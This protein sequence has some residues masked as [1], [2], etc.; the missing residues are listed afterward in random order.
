MKKITIFILAF[1]SV[2]SSHNTMAAPTL[3]SDGMPLVYL[4]GDFNRTNWQPNERYRFSRSGD[5][6]TLVIDEKNA[7]GECSFKI[8]DDEWGIVDLGAFDA[9]IS[10]SGYVEGVRGAS[11]MRTPGLKDAI[12]SFTYTP[13]GNTTIKFV[14]D[15]IEPEPGLEPEPIPGDYPEIYLVGELTSDRWAFT[16]KRFKF[17]NNGNIYTLKI[18]G[19]NPVPAGAQFKIATSDWSTFDIG[20]AEQGITIDNTQTLALRRNGANLKTENGIFD[21]SISFTLPEGDYDYVGVTFTITG[22]DPVMPGPVTGLSGTLPV[23]Y[24][25]V[26]IDEAH[27]AYNNEII[28]KDLSHKNY[29]DYAEYWLDVNGCQWLIDEGAE[30]VGSAEKPL[31]LQIKARGNWTRI[32]FS[33]KPFKLK[34]DK[35]QSLLGLSKSKHFAILAHAD[36][37]KGYLR[38]FTGF[39]LGKRIGLPWTP[40]QQPVEV[41]INGD[42]RGLYFLTESI[43]VDEDRVNIEE[44]GDNV[45]DKELVSGGYIVE[46]DNYDEDDNAQI[47][48]DERVHPDAGR[49]NVDK[50]R[51]TFDTPEE[52]SSL[53]RRFITDQFSIMN[54]YV[55]AGSDELW[56][57]ID[58][59]DAARYYIVEEIVSHVESYHGSTYLFRDRGEGQKWH[60]SP[61]WDFGNAFNGNTDNYFYNCDPYGNTWIPSMRVNKTFNDKVKAT[62][63]WFMS[64]EYDGIIEDID[65]Y[66]GHISDAAKA[67]HKRWADKPAPWGGT[68]VADN[69]D[70]KG[71]RD[72][73]VNHLNSKI[74]WL[75]NQFG[76][77]TVKTYPEPERDTTPAA[78]L[79]DYAAS[80]VENVSTDNCDAN[81]EFYNLQGVR[82]MSSRLSPGVYI[83]VSGSQAEK[84]MIK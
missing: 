76:D 12:I 47:R 34:L 36:D 78:K 30:N 32:G 17:S 26:Y 31:A 75:K 42:Y 50:L 25:N 74:S 24:I 18:D 20:G 39:N 81:S 69:S 15:G 11:N 56:A 79:P 3:D 70:M 67:D 21:G 33:K 54:D 40:S 82:I 73:V 80:G 35:K 29:F 57:Y 49:H 27:T 55:G 5:V 53:Q 4:R 65:T 9:N 77:Y 52:Y 2:L 72:S 14:V 10:S 61:L 46:L 28:D 8:G 13:T 68:G 63:L 1:L 58:L 44:L 19:S 83:R 22:S 60:F 45:D 51:V 66:V 16:D 41:V 59:D 71:R 48:M 64:N 7:I 38:N 43:R 23:L 84:V 6:Y 37:N 62:W